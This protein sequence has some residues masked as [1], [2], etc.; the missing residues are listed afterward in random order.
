MNSPIATARL[1]NQ[2]IARSVARKPAQLVAWLGAVQAQE[3]S[4]A[5]WALGLRLPATTLRRHVEAEV[6]RG[7]IIRT[8]VLRPTW[9]FVALRDADWMLKLTSA[10]IH[11]RM[12]PMHA[13][14]QLDPAIRVRA[15]GVMER[16][17]R[18]GEP[19]TRAELA[20]HLERA[21][22]PSRGMAL[23]LLTLYAELERVMHSGP[24]RGKQPTY[25]RY[26]AHAPAGRQLAGDEAIAELAKRYFR[27]HGPATIRDFVWWST[28][29]TRDAKRALEA[30]QAKHHVIDGLTYWTSGDVPPLAAR[31]RPT[32]RLLPVYDEYFVGYQDRAAVP[33][34]LGRRSGDPF[35]SVLI[36]GGQVAGTW[37]TT[38]Y[39]ES[40]VMH[41]APARRL[42]AT[43]RGSIERIA[44]RYGRFLGVPATL[45]LN[46]A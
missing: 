29:T 30:N 36:I 34:G 21:R 25:V 35:N 33:L 7:A 39:E 44:G 37:K 8:H 45:R 40:V 11:R 42:S 38:Q 10:R 46:G 28:L 16:A 22:L 19:L 3:Y 41:V 17:L 32:P 12:A 15:A 23:A 27:S 1:E 9:H 18:D 5:L 13:R 6:N 2:G 4:A 43:E 24:F 26:G 31:Q 20:V 14:H